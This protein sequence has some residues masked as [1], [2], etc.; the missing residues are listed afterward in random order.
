MQWYSCLFAL[1]SVCQHTLC[2]AFAVLYII[3]L[4][5]VTIGGTYLNYRGAV[6]NFMFN[7]I[8]Y[9]MKLIV[10]F[11][12]LFA[13]LQTHKSTPL[14]AVL[15]IILFDAWPILEQL[16]FAQTRL[17]LWS[18]LPSIGLTG[19]AALFWVLLDYTDVKQELE[20]NDVL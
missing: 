6:S 11:F 3:T 19:L 4:V 8:G 16:T 9:E 15:L 18:S 13:D 12:F 1:T 20:D 10:F 7:S 14:A 17:P 2:P 5:S